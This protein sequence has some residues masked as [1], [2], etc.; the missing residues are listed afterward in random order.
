MEYEVIISDLAQAQLD[1]YLHYIV[2]ELKNEQAA[3]SVLEDFHKTRI[4]LERV[5]GSL[6]ESENDRLRELGYK[7]IHLEKHRYVMVYRV[8][9]RTAMVEG[10]YHELQDYVNLLR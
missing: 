5:A 8:V 2:Y 6:K 1:E 3:K 4:T 10:V 7:V 9:G